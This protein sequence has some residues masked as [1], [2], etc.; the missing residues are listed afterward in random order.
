MQ[1]IAKI[2]VQ[3]HTKAKRYRF[4]P[5][6]GTDFVWCS[7]SKLETCKQNSDSRGT[8]PSAHVPYSH[9]TDT[10]GTNIPASRAHTLQISVRTGSDCQR[11]ASHTV[12]THSR[13]HTH[14]QACAS[15]L[16]LLISSPPSKINFNVSQAWRSNKNTDSSFDKRVPQCQN[17]SAFASHKK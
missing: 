11:A 12:S 8:K 1:I 3:G 9:G 16:S 10:A 7:C 2:W 17:R 4:Y 6:V 13:V 15:S 5:F 14:T